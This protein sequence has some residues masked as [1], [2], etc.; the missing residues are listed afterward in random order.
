MANPMGTGMETTPLMEN[1]IISLNLDKLEEYTIKMEEEHGKRIVENFQKSPDSAVLSVQLDEDE[2][3]EDED[4]SEDDEFELTEEELRLLEELGDDDEDGEEPTEDEDKETSDEEKD[5]L[6]ELMEEL[7]ADLEEVPRGSTDVGPPTPYQEELANDIAEIKEKLE[8]AEEENND[9]KESLKHF[10]HHLDK[11]NTNNAKLLY[12]NKVLVNASLN[13]RQ[14]DKIV[15]AI[16]RANSVKEAK[17]IFETLQDSVGSEQSS[18]PKSLNEAVSRRPSL[19]L[20]ENRN[21]QR[22]EA[23]PQSNRWKKL[24]GIT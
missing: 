12:M 14:K 3:Y 5:I 7:E 23:N 1:S 21:T 19:F 11:V 13:E 20:K 4:S 24:A 15:D 18:N 10:K 16:A 22:E 6:E 17:V 2:E 8:E 9:L